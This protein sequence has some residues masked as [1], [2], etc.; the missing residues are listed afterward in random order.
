MTDSLF[1][2]EVPI[3]IWKK[4]LDPYM[5]YHWGEN[6]INDNIFVNPV[7]NIIPHLGNAKKILDVGC[8]FG[9]VSKILLENVEDLEITGITNSQVQYDYINKNPVDGFNVVLENAL[10]W[11]SEDNYDLIIFFE[12]LT[13]FEDNIISKFASNSD[14]FLI[15]DYTWDFNH[16]S[17][18]WHMHFRTK[19]RFSGMF[20]DNNFSVNEL[21]EYGNDSHEVAGDY[22][23][24]NIENKLTKNQK[25]NSHI[26][27]IRNLFESAKE[28]GFIGGRLYLFEAVKGNG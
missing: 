9:S 2:D 15:R 10:E 11:E 19:E 13:H 1:Y 26:K 12:S 23:L 8:G 7:L 16:F 17:E 3:S 4:I 14:R 5:S 25:N 20:L 27:L 18:E 21:L 24:N 22:W 6:G 28:E